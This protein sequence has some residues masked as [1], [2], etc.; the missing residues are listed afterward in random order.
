ML[1]ARALRARMRVCV[2]VCVSAC[3][4]VCVC[5]LFCAAL[6]VEA[7]L[8]RVKLPV[9]TETGMDCHS[10]VL[11]QIPATTTHAGSPITAATTTIT[12]HLPDLSIAQEASAG[13]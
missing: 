3:T 1:C 8:V 11:W 6:F 5:V 4:C 10:S 2:Y 13:Y 12:P 9:V 7:L